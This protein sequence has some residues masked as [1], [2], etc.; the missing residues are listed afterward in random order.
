ME[1]D[2]LLFSTQVNLIIKNIY[3]SLSPAGFVSD[4]FGNVPSLQ[5]SSLLKLLMLETLK[6]GFSLL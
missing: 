4:R 5:K 3:C 2:I 1:A 6:F